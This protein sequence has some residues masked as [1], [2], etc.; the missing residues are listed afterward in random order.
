MGGS[1]VKQILAVLFVLGVSTSVMA[2]SGATVEAYDIQSSDVPGPQP[3]RVFPVPAAADMPGAHLL[4][5]NSALLDFSTNYVTMANANRITFPLTTPDITINTLNY[6]YG[7]GKPLSVNNSL[8]YFTNTEATAS[9]NRFPTHIPRPGRYANQDYSAVQ[10]ILSDPAEQFGVFTAM[11]SHFATGSP[12]YDDN[13]VLMFVGEGTSKPPRRLWVAVLGEDDTFATAQMQQITVGGMYAPFIK[14]TSN[15]TDPIKSVCVVQDAQE[16][17]N[18]PFGFFNPYSVAPEPAT[19][20]L[21]GLGLLAFAR[22]RG[23]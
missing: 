16:E 4:Y 17:Y 23:K 13:N 9:D 10:F 22:R 14:V 20:T 11:N 21:L 6:Q 15:G 12:P 2:Y 18:A 19:M 3:I 8:F 1:D 5:D 7:T